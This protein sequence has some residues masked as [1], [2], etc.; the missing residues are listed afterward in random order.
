MDRGEGATAFMTTLAAF[1][2]LL[3]RYTGQDDLWIGSPVANR[4]R[5]EI[6]ELIGFFVNTL[7]MRTRTA[8]DPS[9]RELLGRVRET[10]LGAYAHQNVPFERLVEE[11]RPERDPSRSP[12][13]QVMFAVQNA[14]GGE[15]RLPGLDVSGLTA[16]GTGAVQF[17][18]TFFLWPAGDT[19][20]GTLEYSLDLFEAATIDRLAG[21]FQTL[22]AGA[23]GDPVARISDLPLL[24]DAERRQLLDWN[25]AEVVPVDE[26]LYGLFAAQA[27]RTPEA[28]ALI[29]GEERLTY[30]DLAAR[31]GRLA[32]RLRARGVGPEVPVA[33]L[34]PRSADLVVALLAVL[35]AGGFYV[36]IDPNY[37]EERIAFLLADSGAEVVLRE[38]ED[39]GLEAPV[40]E[41]LPGNLAYLIYTSGSTGRPKAVAIEHRS[42]VSL[43]RWAREVFG[44]RE[45]A[46]V[47]A[48]TSVT[49]DLS[50]FEI[51]VP[52]AWGG[53]VVLAADALALSSL[54]AAGEVTLINT[55]PS[56]LAELLRTDALPDSLV[57]VNLAG[58]ALARSLADR[59]YERPGVERLYNLYGPSEDT[60]YSTWALVERAS[61]RGPSI[62]RPVAGTRAWVLDRG[63]R[64][65]P[66]GVPGE[67]CL[68]GGGLARGYHGRPELTAERF[69]P[70]QYAG[71]AG[72]RMYRTGDLARYRADGALEF[73]GRLDHQV[74][75][76]GFRIELGE[77]E[78]VL[79]GLE[80]VREAAVLAREDR[81]AAYVA[82]ASLQ[83]EELREALRR[84]LPEFMVPSLWVT[85]G[86]LPRTATGKLDR[87]ALRAVTPEGVRAAEGFVAPRTPAEERLAAIWSQVLG[88]RSD[89]GVFDNFFDLGGHS[90]LATQVVS[91]LRD[92]LG[93]ELPLRVLFEEPTLAGLARRIEA[94]AR[95]VTTA[96]P[97]VPGPR[98]HAMPLS[99]MQERLWFLHQLDPLSPAYNIPSPMW[100]AGDLRPGL[101]ARTLS[102]VMRRHE[103]LRTTFPVHAGQPYQ[104]IAAEPRDVMV[105]IDLRVLPSSM[106][107]VELTRL[108]SEETLRPFDL[109]EGP[110]MRAV[111]IWMA[112][113]EGRGEGA[114]LLTLHHIVSDAWSTGILIRD[115]ADI[116]GALLRGVP[117]SLPALQ[118]Q[119]ADFA[120]WQRRWTWGDALR[121]EL[122]WW[123]EHL[124]G[125]IPVLQLPADHP[126]PAL[127]SGR[128]RRYEMEL[129]RAFVPA[130]EGLG[131]GQ[132]ATLFMTTLAAFSALLA[133]YTGQ[134][135]LWIG[136]PV[137]GRDRSEIEDLIGFFVNTLVMRTRTEGDPT[138]RELLGRVRE[139]TLGA[140]AH[141]H[142]P[143]EKLVEELRPERDP[144]RSPLFQVVFGLQNT[145]GSSLLELP[146]LE[147]RG[148]ETGED[149]AVQ[150]DL[151]CFLWIEEER[152]FGALEYN[153][154]LFEETTIARLAGHAQ[155]LL[156]DILADSEK[157]LS[158]ISLLADAERQQ[159]LQEWNDTA[160]ALPAADLAA[161]FREQA[162]RLPGA[163]AVMSEDG[164]L[165]YA[166]LAVRSGRLAKRL[167]GL[168]VGPE[169]VVGL[170]AGR[171]PAL[172][173]GMLGILEAGGAYLPLD[174]DYPAERLA[175]MLED[176]RVH[177]ILG[178]PDLLAA[179]PE[180][181]RDAVAL[182]VPLEAEPEEVDGPA[183]AGP[184]PEGLAYVMFTSGSTGR[185]K[186]VGVTHRNVVRLVRG[187][188]FADLGPEQVWLQLAPVSFDASTLEVWGALANGGRLA[189][190]PP[191]RPALEEVGEAVARWGVTSLWLTA[192]LFHQMVD[193]P[194]E[195][196]RPLRQLLA[197]GDVLSPPHVRRALEAL[198][199][200]ALIN[201]YGPTE[202]TT[203]TTCHPVAGEV[204]ANVPIGLPIGNTRVYVLDRDL[205]PVPIGCAGELYAAG[206]GLAR[207]Y[208][209]RP[210][211]TAERF[212]PDPFAAGGR[213]YRTGDQARRRADGRVEFLGRRDGQVKLRGFRV[214]LGEVEAALAGHPE[215]AAA[216]VLV[217]DDRL[218][219]FV[220]PAGELDA[221]MLRQ[222]LL[223]RL[224]DYMVPAEWAFL[225]ALPLSP[226]GKVDRRALRGVTLEGVRAAEGF[227]APRTPAEERLAA[228]WAEV[229]NASSPVGA[230]DDFFELG[231]HSLLAT[232]V[233][234]RVRESFGIDLPLRALFESP[235]LADLA[236]EVEAEAGRLGVSLPEVRRA[237]ESAGHPLS[238]SQERLWFLDRLTPGSAAYN[239]PS[240]LRIRGPLDPAILE[241][242]F[243]EVVRRHESLRTRFA[244]RDG[245]PVQSVD[246]PA[247]WPLPEIDL[248]GLPEARRRPEAE[249]WMEEEGGWPFDLTRGPLL[250]T[251][252]LRIDR[253]E[254]LLLLTLHHIISDGWSISVLIR[255]LTSLYRAFAG[256]QPSPLPELPLQYAD[257]SRWQR[258]RLSGPALE[259]HLAYWRK[260]LA[261][262]PPSLDLPLDRPRPAVQTFRGSTVFLDLDAGLASALRALSVSQRASL[263]MVLLAAFKLLLQRMSGQE[264]IVVGAPVAGRDRRDFES[265][266]GFFLNTLTL[267]TDLSGRPSFRELVRR[268]RSTV[269]GAFSH[270]DVPFE[271]LLADVQPERDLSRTPLFQV[272][273]N[274]LNFPWT[275][276]E[277]PG[278]VT[279]ESLNR[280]DVEA[281]FDVTVYVTEAGSEL[282]LSFV[283]NAD[284]FDRVRIEEMARQ[285]RSVLAQAAAAPD[286]PIDRISLLTPEAVAL[287]PDP[288]APLGGEWHGA[289]HELF[290]A[291][292][293]RHPERPALIDAEGTW[294]Y[295]ELAEAVDRLAARLREGGVSSGDRVA[296]YAHRSAPVVWAVLATL[297]AGAAF[298]LL[299]PAY[300]AARLAE[301]IRMAAPRACLEVAAAGPVPP[302]L[303]PLLPACRL[304]LPGGGPEG[305]RTLLAGLP[306]AGPP[307]AVG[308]DDVAYVAFTSGST[309]APKGILGRHG[310]LSHF[311][312]WQYETFGLGETDRYSMLSGL[313]HDPLQRDMFTP[314]STG[315]TLCIPTVEE[316]ATPGR[317][318]VWM[319]RQEVTVAHLTLAMGQILTEPGPGGPGGETAQIPTLRYTLLVGDVLTRLDVDRIRRI[320]PRVTVVNLYGSTETQRAVGFHVVAE[321][322]VDEGRARQVL[323]L[324]RGMRDVQLLVVSGTDAPTLAG[325]GEVGEIWVRS[326]HLAQGYL[327]D[328]TLTAE[329]FRTNPFTSHS[330]GRL[331]DRVYRTG[332]LGRYLP[333]G[334]A[335]FAGRADQQ[336]KIR[337]FRIEL[338][339]IE[340]TLGR[341]P[342]VREAVVLAR[343]DSP[344]PGARRLVAYVVPDPEWPADAADAADIEALRDALRER[345]PAYM[346]PA[347][348]VRL[349][350]LP[351]TPNGKV[352]RRALP[353]PEGLDADLGA[354]YVEPES[355]LE[356]TIA[357]VWR[358][359]LGLEKVGV[360]HNFFDLGGHSL[361]LVRLHARLQEALGR[362]L[363][364]IE[365]FNYPNVRALAEH[366]GRKAAEASTSGAPNL[367]AAKDRAQKQ[368]EAARRQKELAKARRRNG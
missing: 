249:R 75:I 331:G 70:D 263:F 357:G 52:L 209:G 349:D 306:P 113:V 167:T 117:P 230:L 32:R 363:S 65:A 74:K 283:Y 69:V 48:S 156:A 213:L 217:R 231:G 89:I 250:R 123:K 41:V 12:L 344:D 206:E 16:D 337:G 198:P 3:D 66:V 193:G 112:G 252:L 11:L 305:A 215:V 251:L 108:A 243:D 262:S 2:A 179:L 55:V 191:R 313:A 135:D 109:A 235:R 310:P 276:A 359:V 265:L 245:E 8:G 169:S 86:A 25:T 56:A 185:P 14:P 189:V 178:Q 175:G 295:G 294:T 176:A 62:G 155:A 267:R 272:F 330:T 171:S 314:L 328:E 81:L 166:D 174:P 308:P 210:D 248:T 142:V 138:F 225:D 101:L 327:E 292:A 42:A 354:A 110:V 68:G 10:A 341:L 9:F 152:F 139:A 1:L 300:P 367:D 368:I 180:R 192:G 111:L 77:V 256:G 15:L 204:G 99:L 247:R 284:L 145:P 30:A 203:F 325:V 301:M 246:P 73:L 366:L 333:D 13:F 44:G 124:A 23:V 17:D 242:S 34:M 146:G 353:A 339:E 160:A 336:V 362:E 5:S 279:V 304:S 84:R 268:E 168:G 240:P 194:I 219:A 227:V 315:G 348:F 94:E 338:G 224:P 115:V 278:G 188:G 37:P 161:L 239:I 312:P 60:T 324:G 186:P 154:D 49:F 202:G 350:R 220:V 238:Y 83:V 329:R 322:G 39:R 104:A 58:E 106:R 162:A 121:Q 303:E 201:G 151:N 125:E 261:G 226:N 318:A 87:R 85:L 207:G 36:P 82:P 24:T 122:D 127:M 165:T 195:W 61:E 80:G 222:F 184:L 228:I 100:L 296:I 298:V 258:E 233:V 59:I 33:V 126:R 320:A 164:D 150:F 26:T 277:L 129:P 212:V 136:A 199:G 6:E 133:R 340:A 253:E 241:R 130:L 137:A 95:G 90:L 317:L 291:R 352:D 360:R 345:L 64:P 182:T 271:K 143:F 356:Q 290:A 103:T 21:H 128:G 346:V 319:A 35:E 158:A 260:Q 170:L 132:G 311:L 46:G 237:V 98:D 50:V 332:D 141:Q 288:T 297:E 321:G 211:L 216:A 274:M 45:L 187:G 254:L 280:T 149:I 159:L 57:T 365:L 79:A 114:L 54:P 221:R 53:T 347:A 116:Y 275:G 102:A 131:R 316:I 293:R 229:L 307:V 196:L 144:S 78:S 323:P 255:E 96:S 7:V 282:Q 257:F 91:R 92:Q 28:L 153:R 355:D 76:R 334:Q 244:D 259:A 236:V 29:A 273:F 214:E 4:N 148:L 223:E 97:I 190:F 299:D 234:S 361:L 31:A 120:Q 173:V 40:D 232:Q 218:A 342:G 335:V 147:I 264:D 200:C 118:V 38:I 88:A 343:Q 197:G 72:A 302:E 20:A 364:L 289:V 309:G 172:I 51:F 43:A 67:L 71:E 205:R 93:V 105:Q 177:L 18:L 107:D 270:Q 269:L 326:P 181:V 47:L 134:E 22:L 163:V 27:R 281:K 287:L 19:L 119:Y 157:P 183:P 266:I 63:L 351:V 285:Y 358:E 208:L 286:V 140:F